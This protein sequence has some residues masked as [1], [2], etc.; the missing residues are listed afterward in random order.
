MLAAKLRVLLFLFVAVNIFVLVYMSF[1]L[2]FK[3]KTNSII[4]TPRKYHHCDVE[5]TKL[6]DHAYFRLSLAFYYK[7]VQKIRLYL[8][9]N[10]QFK[11]DYK[12]LVV[13]NSSVYNLTSIRKE[14]L[15]TLGIYEFGYLEASLNAEHTHQR[16]KVLV[17]TR[18]DQ[19]AVSI[20][21]I[22]K[23][24][25]TINKVKKHAMACSAAYS[26]RNEHAKLIEWWI[27]INKV[28]INKYNLK[29]F[30]CV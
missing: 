21:L 10:N 25:I 15:N 20:N 23:N 9:S 26:F 2:K 3:I 28:N 5:W 12:L 17:S 1:A 14:T 18:Q 29:S 6:N 27:E 16:L 22:V 19:R 13:S 11:Y 30:G 8:E 24:M 7:D 4:L